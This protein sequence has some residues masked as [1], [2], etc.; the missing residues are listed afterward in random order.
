[1]AIIL[2]IIT[3]ASSSAD[4]TYCSLPESWQATLHDPVIIFSNADGVSDESRLD[5]MYVIAATPNLKPR[6]SNPG[7]AIVIWFLHC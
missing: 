6:L 7:S 4:Q 5:C 2:A 3:L 1:V